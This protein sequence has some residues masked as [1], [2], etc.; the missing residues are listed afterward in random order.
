MRPNRRSISCPT[1]TAFLVMTYRPMIVLP[2]V[3]YDDDLQVALN[4]LP[5]RVSTYK[6]SCNV[7]TRGAGACHREPFSGF[8]E[9]M[10]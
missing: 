1:H 8:A 5:G 9:A 10:F 3:P 4:R 6:S 2:E 7:I